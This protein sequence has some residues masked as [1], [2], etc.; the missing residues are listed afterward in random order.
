MRFS[1]S[2]TVWSIHHAPA[3]S[4]ARFPVSENVERSLRRRRHPERPHMCF[5]G[6]ADETGAK[7]DFLRAK[8]KE[9]HIS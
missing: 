1:A 2:S 9:S 4:I 3:R 7:S 5:E 6:T 8:D